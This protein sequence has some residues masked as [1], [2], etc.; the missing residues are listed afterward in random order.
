M[1][2]FGLH[3]PDPPSET[4]RGLLYSSALLENPRKG[5]WIVFISLPIPGIR[6]RRLRIPVLNVRRIHRFAARR[7]GQAGGF[8]FVILAA[9]ATLFALHALA[10]R[11]TSRRVVG[12][13]PTLV[14]R[15]EDLKRIWN[16]EVESGHYPSGQ[17][18]ESSSYVYAKSLLSPCRSF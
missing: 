3:R 13:I 11:A 10:K 15:R 7:F 8:L 18:S 2:T 16:W 6:T 9:F 14:Y 17:K 5:S 4:G 12:D 1:P